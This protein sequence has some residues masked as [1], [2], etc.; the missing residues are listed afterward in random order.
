LRITSLRWRARREHD[1]FAFVQQQQDS[2]RVVSRI[3][4]CVKVGFQTL[5][6]RCDPLKACIEMCDRTPRT[7]SHSIWSFG[8]CR[9]SSCIILLLPDEALTFCSH[10]SSMETT[11]QLRKSEGCIGC[12]LYMS[13]LTYR[14]KD[15]I[16]WCKGLD[17]FDSS[18]HWLNARLCWGYWVYDGTWLLESSGWNIW[19][20]TRPSCL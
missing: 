8:S 17:G 14:S 3:G 7:T 4:C 1:L 6:R 20:R 18:Y 16:G 9:W 13:A 12:P 11:K 15:S 10:S 2:A 19:Y 5:H